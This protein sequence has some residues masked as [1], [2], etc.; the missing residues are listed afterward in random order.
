MSNVVLPD[1]LGPTSRNEG[2][3]VALL[4][5]KKMYCNSNGNDMAT[6]MA[7][8]IASGEGPIKAE[9][10]SSSVPICANEI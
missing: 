1:P 4:D 5:R 9:A 6:M 10:H 2:K 3:F 7:E 8:S